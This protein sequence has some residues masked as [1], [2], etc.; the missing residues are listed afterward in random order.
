MQ[1]VKNDSIKYGLRS[2]YDIEWLTILSNRQELYFFNTVSP[3]LSTLFE[4]YDFRG[5]MHP[6]DY[7]ALKTNITYKHILRTL[8]A[9][10]KSQISFFEGFANGRKNLM[11]MIDKEIKKSK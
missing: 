3:A 7:E 5:P 8:I 9:N 1:L 11:E 6:M 4:S 10:R 2:A